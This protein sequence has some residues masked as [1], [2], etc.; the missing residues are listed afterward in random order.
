MVVCSGIAT[1]DV[2]ANETIGEK[3]VASH[4]SYSFAWVGRI[5]LLLLANAIHYSI[6]GLK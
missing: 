5:Y 4:D 6:K 1:L 3:L 2:F